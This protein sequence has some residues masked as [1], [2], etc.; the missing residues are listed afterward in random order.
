MWRGQLLQFIPQGIVQAAAWEHGVDT[1]ARCYSVWSHLAAMVF[2]Q[3]AHAFS[4]HDVCGLLGLNRRAD[5]RVCGH[6]GGTPYAGPTPTT[7]ALRISWSAC[8]GAVW[9]ICTAVSRL[10]AASPK[11]RRLLHRFKVKVHAVD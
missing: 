10:S 4:L 2:V 6:A 9:H 3:L 7:G 5:R 1:V 11:G 8:S